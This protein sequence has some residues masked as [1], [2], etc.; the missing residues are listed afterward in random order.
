MCCSLTGP[1]PIVLVLVLVWIH[2]G[3]TQPQTVACTVPDTSIHTICAK[4]SNPVLVNN[5]HDCFDG[6]GTK[7][8]CL[9]PETS[10]IA[11]AELAPYSSHDITS[12]AF[13]PVCFAFNGVGW[14]GRGA[15]FHNDYGWFCHLQAR[16][17]AC[18]NHGDVATGTT[19]TLPE[20]VPRCTCDCGYQAGT[21]FG[22]PAQC[23]STGGQTSSCRNPA[24]NALV[25]FAV[26]ANGV[27]ADGANNQVSCFCP[28]DTCTLVNAGGNFIP[29]CLVVNGVAYTGQGFYTLIANNHAWVYCGSTFRSLACN[30]HG[31]V[32]EGPAFVTPVA[33][34][35]VTHHICACD[36]GYIDVADSHG[37]IAR[38]SQQPITSGPYTCQNPATNALVIFVPTSNPAPLG[39]G[40]CTTPDGLTQIMC[41]CPAD[42]CQVT[43]TSVVCKVVNGVGYVGSRFD[44]T[45]P[46]NNA[47]MFCSRPYRTVVCNG[48]G[49]VPPGYTPQ[50]ND[51]VRVDGF[52][53]PK[54]LGPC[55]CDDNWW[56]N[57]SG[58]SATRCTFQSAC[59]KPAAPTFTDNLGP[60]RPDPR[61]GHPCGNFGTCNS[62]SKC[63]CQTG[64]GGL[65]CDQ[66]LLCLTNNSTKE[67]SGAGT[68]LGLFQPIDYLVAG[69]WGVF[70]GWHN[71]NY[72]VTGGTATNAHNIGS[73]LSLRAQ[74]ALYLINADAT[75]LN[76]VLANRNVTAAA[77]ACIKGQAIAG[78]IEDCYKAVLKLQF[79]GLAGATFRT[80]LNSRG[81]TKNPSQFVRDAFFSYY[82][83]FGLIDP[84]FIAPLAAGLNSTNPNTQV[85]TLAVFLA[86]SVF[87]D[88]SS[89]SLA[90]TY[91]TFP[92]WTCNCGSSPILTGTSASGP[93]CSFY[94]PATNLFGTGC[95]GGFGTLSQP[96][97]QC[98]A[99][100]VCSCD[101]AFTG[102]ACQ[103][104]LLNKCLD[105]VGTGQVCS[106]SGPTN[107]GTC[108][109]YFTPNGLGV[110]LVAANCSCA[111]TWQGKYCQNSVCSDTPIPCG[112]HGTCNPNRLCTCDLSTL[113]AST[114]Q[115]SLPILWSGANCTDN[116]V[117]KCGLFTATPNGFGSG[118]WS[119]CNNDGACRLNGTRGYACFCT[120][121]NFGSRCQFSPCSPS[122]NATTQ[123]CNAHTTTCSCRAMWGPSPGCLQNQCVHGKPSPD[124]SSC[125]CDKFYTTDG[126]GH[127]IAPRCPLVAN[128]PNTG[129]RACNATAGDPMCFG[130]PSSTTGCCYDQCGTA[131]SIV[132][133]QPVCACSPPQ[134]FNQ[135]SGICFPV[136]HGGSASLVGGSV[137]CTCTNVQ[138][139]TAYQFIDG[140]CNVFTCANG[141]SAHVGGCQC[142][143]A[144][145]GPLC[146]VNACRN[147]GSPVGGTC[148][149]VGG[150]TGS[151]CQ[152]V[153]VVQSSTGSH[154]SSSSTGHTTTSSSSSSTATHVSSSTASHS[155]SSSSS[156][157]TATQQS[158]S[159]STGTAVSNQ[160]SSSSS[161]LSFTNKI[162]A[163]TIPT[164]VVGA[165]IITGIAIAIH[166]C[167]AGTKTADAAVSRALI[168]I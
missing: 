105:P 126:S 37:N 74:A 92:A 32:V 77:N 142:L 36:C 159:S 157:S 104:G 164:V 61:N 5:V 121:S 13:Y 101:A 163:I 94:C 168:S 33:Y 16:P 65:A 14:F 35:D 66:N 90:A 89:P 128:T 112:F 15:D 102:S 127:C 116:A 29:L 138:Y 165:L 3:H 134:E 69:V 151:V 17:G 24:T 81:Y 31:D 73:D 131:C 21:L 161:S 22:Q 10:C 82:P 70:T 103:I 49:D 152:T 99:T 53:Q 50:V 43:S 109:E 91:P 160:T 110:T 137:L 93:A 8:D 79:T 1:W 71:L 153:P 143:T 26:Y 55:K 120:G 46:S 96:Q 38:C 64:W 47:Y 97:G 148:A 123:T 52:G 155:G 114:T 140:F 28:A 166:A 18:S 85:D 162:I 56:D 117:S 30:G 125:V 25:N 108:K 23:F 39:G 115:S 19:L 45:I 122:C 62:N 113:Q 146:T 63:T 150:F 57:G 124:G 48:H 147:G 133:G 12:N 136:C 130:D 75:P 20:I 87:V 135:V 156:S 41:F 106:S 95:N 145:G 27:C 4:V 111:P 107:Q 11:D 40:I 80:F 167:V 44:T 84:T 6:S 119:Q 88:R 76:S 139:A 118:V 141:G 154:S 72:T 58:T 9:C 86:Y 129:I 67:C 34:T 60:H 132:G 83:R 100:G 51:D 149:C 68:C 144:W 7:T 98:L 42:T 158:S 78:L 54:A 2:R 59:P